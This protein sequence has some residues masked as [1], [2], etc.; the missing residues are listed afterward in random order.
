ME[1]RLGRSYRRRLRAE[2]GWP[3]ST[4]QLSALSWVRHAESQGNV[5]DTEAQRAGAPRLQLSHRDPDMPLSDL[6]REQSA[7]LGKAWRVRGMPP[8]ALVLSSPYER[9][10][11]TAELAVGHA[12][13]DV[14]VRR[15]E[16]L[17]ERDLGV[18]DGYTKS[19]IQQTFPEEADRRAWIGKFYYRPPGGESWADVAGRVRAVLTDLLAAQIAGTV[20]LVSHQAV[21][22]LA[23]YVLED[24]TEEQVLDLDAHARM[25]NTA[26]T[27]YARRRGGW[28]HTSGPDTGHLEQA[29]AP[30][31]AEED[32]DAV[33][34]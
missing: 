18:L 3:V 19:G 9:A 26:V 16:R 4:D 32:A 27:D 31:T 14:E 7:A 12:G 15:D 2:C 34:P 13:W 24:L 11:H 33:A 6:G 30:V 23:R 22:M 17:R 25:A 8:P 1:W 5:A 20:V 21:I 29:A 10:L 28:V